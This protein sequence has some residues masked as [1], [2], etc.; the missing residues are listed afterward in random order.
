MTAICSK[1][2]SEL[3]ITGNWGGQEVVCPKCKRKI[4]LPAKS[5]L[6]C[7]DVIREYKVL[8]Q[9]DLLKGP[10]YL[11]DVNVAEKRLNKLASEGWRVVSSSTCNID[12]FSVAA[13]RNELVV[14][15][16]RITPVV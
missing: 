5:D 15:L 14:I 7:D 16:E 1:C 8:S 3:S 10:K 9:N 13:H 4:Q 11:Y 2:R 12:E 6:Y